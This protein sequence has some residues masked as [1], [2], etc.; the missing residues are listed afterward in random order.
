M[1]CWGHKMKGEELRALRT[2]AKMTQTALADALGIGQT[3]VSAM[4]LDE[5]KISRRTE[6][7]IRFILDHIEPRT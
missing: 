1:L 7:A 6:L 5:R 3:M 2:K 4:E